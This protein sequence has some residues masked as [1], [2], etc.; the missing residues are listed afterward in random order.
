MLAIKAQSQ[1]TGKV[2]ANLLPCRI[3]HDGEVDASD[4]HWQPT[5]ETDGKDTVH[6]RGRKMFGKAV[7]LPES[8]EGKLL[9]ITN[10]KVEERQDP[11]DVDEDG[12]EA[13]DTEQTFAAVE[14]SQFDKMM[15]WSHGTVP[16]SSEDPYV[17]GVE[18]W[19]SM[20]EAIHST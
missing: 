18:E 17:K 11:M 1:T 20:A 3:N 2:T 5:T 7:N 4:R 9:K 16:E 6:Y 14:V 10:E 12:S 13:D 15:V 8:Y 19:I